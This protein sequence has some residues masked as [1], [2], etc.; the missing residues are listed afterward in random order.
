M[1]NEGNRIK[2]NNDKLI[3]INSQKTGKGWAQYQI[4][5]N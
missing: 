3:Q 4:Y 5:E 2:H 1:P